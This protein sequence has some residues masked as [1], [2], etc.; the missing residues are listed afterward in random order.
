MIIVTKMQHVFVQALREDP[1]TAEQ[2]YAEILESVK[3]IN[4]GKTE[5]APG[6]DEERETEKEPEAED[7]E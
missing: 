2:L 7:V 4:S 5:A 3:H 1:D 6:Q